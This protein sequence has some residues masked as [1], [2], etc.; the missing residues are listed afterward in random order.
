MI[1]GFAAV[2]VLLAGLV[3]AAQVPLAGPDAHAEASKPWDAPPDADETGHLIF[4]GVVGLLKHW[5]NIYHMNGHNVVPAFVTPGT[6]LFHGRG[7]AV[8]PAVPEWLSLDAEHSLIFTNHGNS[9]HLLTYA[10][11]RPLKLLYFDGA[12]AYYRSGTLDTQ[13]VLIYGNVTTGRWNPFG[14]IIDLCDWGKEFGIDGYLRMEFDFEIMYCNFTNG[15]EVVSSVNVPP[16]TWSLATD[17]QLDDHRFPLLTHGE[18]SDSPVP[19]EPI[20]TAGPVP[21]SAPSDPPRRRPGGPGGPGGPGRGPPIPP[22]PPE[23]WQGSLR[24]TS[25]VVF[26]A[27]HAGYWH[28]FAP[29]TGIKIDYEGLITFYNPKYMSLVEARRT[30][31]S[32]S[33]YRL[34]NISREDGV[35]F[36]SELAHVLTRHGVKGSGIDWGNVMRHIMERHADRLEFLKHLLQSVDQPANT[37]TPVNLTSVVRE[38]RQQVLTMLAPYLSRS[39]V[40]SSRDGATSANRTW[41]EPAISL[42]ASSYTKYMDVS[43]FTPQE[44]ILKSA[45]EATAREICRTLGLVWTTTFGAESVASPR[46]QRAL[47]VEWRTEIERLM[48]WLDWAVWLKCDPGCSAD[49][50]CSL[51]GIWTGIE[52]PT[53][54][55]LSL[56]HWQ[57]GRGGGPGPG[58]P[59]G[60]GEGGGRREAG[61]GG[62]P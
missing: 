51:D 26:E 5:S 6:L 20:P 56:L 18:P 15:L 36:K 28:N 60:P 54:H 61:W 39:S 12:S 1:A 34:L 23:G 10:A 35:M 45:T 42:C 21:N 59:S 43:T 57:R 13:D 37:T 16:I 46:T 27:L 8:S 44:H 31:D 24:S 3:S 52:H 48:G 33:L 9:G 55:C 29:L 7:D 50:I 53:P 49:E 58:S 30:V 40:P 22:D 32:P 41:L 47:L 2:G 14:R 4:D 19:A 38:T 62:R 17:L 25:Q 11:T